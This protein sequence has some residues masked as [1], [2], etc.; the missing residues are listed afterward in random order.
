MNVD[1]AFCR[2]TG[3]VSIGVII[4]DCN[5]AVCLA[6][7]RDVP[8]ARDAEEVEALATREGLHYAAEESETPAVLET[9]CSSV[10]ALLK[11]ST[12]DRGQLCLIAEEAR[13]AG[14]L[15]SEWKVVHTRKREIV[16]LMS[17]HNWL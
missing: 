4:R 5:A 16:L 6:A 8:G 1:G 15:M 2:S 11:N 17:S 13:Q 12:R 3:A 7:W 9:D 14:S 10:Q